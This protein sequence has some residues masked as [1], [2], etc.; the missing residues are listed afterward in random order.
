MALTD[1]AVLVPGVGHIWTGVVGTATK[2]TLTALNT[3]ASAGTVPSGWTSL[4][5][6]SLADVLVFDQS[7]GETDVKGSWQNPSLRTVITSTAVDF[8]TVKSLQVQDN[9]ILSLYYGGGDAS[10]AN[11]FAL[12][13]SP[14]ATEKAVTVVLLDGST[15]V[16]L[17]VPKAS[18]LRAD[19]PD[20]SA[21]D[22]MDFPLKF[23]ILKYLTNPKATWISDLIGA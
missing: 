10:T 16:A 2:P 21:D 13:D 22:F 14:A 19:A 4:G 7:G 8:F 12:P 1:G 18:I 23:T 20:V 15:P 5:H 17:Y 3:F 9:T 6:T 11:E